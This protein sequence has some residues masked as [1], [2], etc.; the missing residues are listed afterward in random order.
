MAWIIRFICFGYGDGIH[1]EWI[2]YLGIILHGVCYDFF[3]VSGQIYTDQK[4]GEHYKSSAQGLITLATY[5]VGMAIGSK[6]SG[7]ALE[8]YQ[9]GDNLYDWTKIWWF[10]T[11]IS[12]FVLI[13]FMISFKDKKTSI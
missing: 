2:L 5:G 12:I 9:I 10:P 6:L 13:V 8:Y 1:S 3:F 4:A 11:Y 7:L